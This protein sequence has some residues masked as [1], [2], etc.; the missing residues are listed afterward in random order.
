MPKVSVI[1][2]CYGVEKYLDR[3]MES[4]LMQTLT[5]IEIIL[6]D[7]E[8]PDRVPEMCDEYA[9]RDKRIKV[10]HK[11]NGGLGYARNSGLDVATGEYVAFVD[12]DD[13]VD[14]AIYETL[15]DEAEK[16]KADAVFCGFNLEGSKGHWT[17]SNEIQSTRLF[18]NDDVTQFMLDM[19]AN[20]PEEPNERRYYMSVW[21]AIYKRSIIVDN[22]IRF[23]SEREVVSEDIP[24]QVDFLKY[25]NKIV[26]IPDNMYYYCNNGTS[27]SATYKSEKYERFKYLRNVLIDKLKFQEN[28]NVRCDRL[29]IGYTRYQLHHLMLSSESNKIKQIRCIVNDPIWCEIKK[30]YPIDNFKRLDLKLMYWMILHKFSRLL[31]VNS[32]IV[33][34]LRKLLSRR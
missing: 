29:F 23:L 3:C 21:R 22:D 11:A 8:S 26:Y 9:K 14:L 13:Y 17:K 34:N 18:Q 2:P 33:N 27:L 32:Y 10:V 30:K 7:D 15:Y 6:V 24:F 25:S 5:D 16:H 19:V 1:I 31:I 28:A 4:V 12:S 20:A